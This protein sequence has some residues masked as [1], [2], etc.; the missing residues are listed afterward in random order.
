LLSLNE[1]VSEAKEKGLSFGRWA[2]LKEAGELEIS[3]DEL[4]GDMVKAVAV[5]RAAVESG[6]SGQ[7]SRGGLVGGNAK[8]MALL[9]AEQK[10]INI[11]GDI[12]SDAIQNA[13][14][15]GEANAA[16][17]KILAAPTAGASG[18]LPG[19]FFAI[20][21]PLNL[22]EKDLAYGLVTAGVIGLVIASRASLA[23]ALG[24]CQAECG[25]AAAMAAGAA[26][27][28]AGGTPDAVAHAA[29]L[30]LKG[31]LGLVCDPV[32]GLVEVPCVKRNAAAAGQALVAAQMALAGIESF[33]PA[34]EVFD[35]MKAVGASMPGA[36]KETAEGGVAATPTALAWTRNFNARN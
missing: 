28:M 8:K 17:G 4:L 20:E 26:A 14:A 3:Q 25:S 16:M 31:M 19:V 34:D 22:T 24:G 6:L 11:T 7:K 30:A 32:A 21:K 9:R 1:F 2:F 35:A 15:T 33:I 27:D 23:G 29:A 13:L 5:M 36:L 18:V 12:L 10:Y